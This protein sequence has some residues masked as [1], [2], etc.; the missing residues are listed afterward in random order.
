MKIAFY[1]NI[2]SPHQVPLAEELVKRIGAENFR[3]VPWEK[4]HTER[5]EMGWGE[6]KRDWITDD[7]GA[8]DA[9][10][11]IYTATREVP[12]LERWL[13]AGKT[14]LYYGERWF[15]PPIGRL[16]MLHPRFRKRIKGM[17]RLAKEYSAFK[18]LPIGVHAR[19][20]YVRAGVPEAKMTTWGYFVAPSEVP[21]FRRPSAAGLKVLWAG[22]RI[23]LKNVEIIEKACRRVGV[24]LDLV[25]NVPIERVREEM[26]GHEVFV[27]ASNGFDGWGAV[28]SEALEEGMIV[29][30]SNEAG[31]PATLLPPELRFN[32]R[33]HRALADL[34]GRLK[35]GRDAGL[36]ASAA[37]ALE[38]YRSNWT[39]AAAAG[40]FLELCK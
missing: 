26:R 15:K 20:D 11:V 8:L 33:D 27:F 7:A 35:D 1:V 4:F 25:S 6:L 38:N 14:V 17:V 24:P 30:G 18:F 2:V 34:L 3:Y 5:A 22:R 29:L 23:P 28:V 10:D 37:S 40:K 39:A 32:C 12:R 9:A 36:R 13:Q 16:R 19:R 31:A 21:D